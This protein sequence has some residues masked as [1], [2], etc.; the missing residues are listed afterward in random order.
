MH[1]R[2]FVQIVAAAVATVIAGLRPAG[3][4]EATFDQKAF[5]AAQAAGK[6]VIVAV[7]A[8]WCPICARQKPIMSQLETDP[9]L[10]DITVFLVDFDS[11][12]DIVRGFGVQK[13]STLIAFHGKTEKTRSTGETDAAKLRA[14]YA[15]ALT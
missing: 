1:R 14:I 12:K 13:Q 11:Q 3:A 9:A 5:D 7:H 10:K 15:A 4:A 6:P 8:T 2:V